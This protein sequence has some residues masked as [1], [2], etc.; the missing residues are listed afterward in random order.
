MKRVAVTVVSMF[1]A[2]TI[3]SGSEAWQGVGRGT[4][5]RAGHAAVNAPARKVDLNTASIRELQKLPGFG[6]EVAGRIVQHR[7]YH[8]LDELISRKV[9][10]RKEFARIKDRIRVNPLVEGRSAR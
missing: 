1:G 2:A 9:L 5:A 4:A 10:G 7:P 8:T 3:I 6:P